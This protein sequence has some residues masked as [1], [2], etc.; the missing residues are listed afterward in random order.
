MN[1]TLNCMTFCG[2][3][4]YYFSKQSVLRFSPGEC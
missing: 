2:D 3:V 4:Y 1:V